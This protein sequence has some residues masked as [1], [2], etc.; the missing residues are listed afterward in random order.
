MTKPILLLLG[1]EDLDTLATPELA[2]AAARRTA[3]I[4]ASGDLTTNRVQVG[5]SMIW[6]RLL[7]GIIP[8]LD[9]FGYKQFH[10][11]EKRV[12]YHIH[13]FRRST[14]DPL[15]TLDGR[16]I[17]SLRTA[18]TAAVAVA[19]HVVPGSPVRVGVVGSGEE[20]KEGLR[21][22]HGAIRIEAVRVFSPT[23]ANRESYAAELSS[24]L[25]LTVKPVASV[26]EALESAEVAYVATSA[27]GAPFLSFDDVAHVRVVVA[28]GS[29]RPNQRELKGDVL[30]RAAHVVVDCADALHE[31]GDVIEAVEAYGFDARRAVLLGNDLAVTPE[32]FDGPVIFKS[33]GSVEQDLVLA[34][35]LVEAAVSAGRGH[36]I[37]T[38]ASLRIML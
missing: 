35:H 19:H 28:I 6:S 10:R 4:V 29:T 5:D 27:A 15:A 9:L 14:G 34:H 37:D 20:T 24:E 26:A 11:V 2:L 18:A 25:G 22:L 32:R 33:I 16:R 21:M 23:P 1:E 31:S 8:S 38:I 12:R 13:L 36:R 30:A 17:T 7:V 3:Q